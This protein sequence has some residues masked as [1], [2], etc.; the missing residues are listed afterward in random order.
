MRQQRRAGGSSVV[1]HKIVRYLPGQ[2][3]SA[4]RRRY[5][6]TPTRLT[7]HLQQEVNLCALEVQ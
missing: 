5:N 2:S 3:A 6:T 4:S 7:V 1:T